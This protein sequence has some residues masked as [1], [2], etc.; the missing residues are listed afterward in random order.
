[1]LLLLLSI[2]Y[3]PLYYQSAEE[4]SA[5]RSGIDIITYM[6]CVVGGAGIA[7]GI[8][9]KTGLPKPFLVG[10]PL[11]ATIGCALVF[12]ELAKHEV[13]NTKA[14]Y[15]YQVLLGLGAGGAL[16]NTI[17]AIQAEYAH[18]PDMVPQ[19]TSLVNFTQLVGGIIG[20]A[21]AG[22]IF[23]N[24]LGSG[25]A[26]YAPDLSAETAAGVKQSVQ[27]LYALTGPDKIAVTHAYTEALGT[28]SSLQP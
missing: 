15:G 16:Q 19:S 6:F 18:R 26:Q 11:L 10:S 1:M 17:I 2:Y 3:L 4:H 8:I 28:F 9:N 24:K 7:G 21:I 25:I 23:G 14:L 27:V 20:I 22:T 12:W 5:T 13:P